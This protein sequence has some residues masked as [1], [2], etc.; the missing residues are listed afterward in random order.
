MTE[1][2][3]SGGEQRPLGP[4]IALRHLKLQR[5]TGVA[6]GRHSERQ[7]ADRREV[8]RHVHVTVPQARDERLPGTVDD[9]RSG[10]Q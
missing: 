5:A 8:V 6:A 4:A 10:R 7:F 9:A 1:S 2:K 3:H